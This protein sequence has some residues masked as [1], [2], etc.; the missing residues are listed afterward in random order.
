MEPCELIN[1]IYAHFMGPGVTSTQQMAM[2]LGVF[3]STSYS[4]GFRARYTYVG[5]A[6]SAL[7]GVDLDGRI[8]LVERGDCFFD[9]KFENVIYC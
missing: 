9:E 7:S 8:G 1:H 3:S 5:R 2:L 4:P 6:C